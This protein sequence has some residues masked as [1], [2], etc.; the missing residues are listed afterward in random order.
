MRELELHN[1]GY[2]EC[3]V[4]T[5][6][7]GEIFMVDCGSMNRIQR[8]DGG[9]L[10]HQFSESI[11]ER[12]RESPSRAFLL[13]HCHRDHLC[14][15]WNILAR[16]PRYFERI[17]LP[18]SPRDR[19]GR[20]LLLEFA[21]FHTV[22]LRGQSDYARTNLAQLRLFERAARA[23]GPEA[24]RGVG[25]GDSFLFDGVSY[26]VLWPRREDYPFS[27]LFAETVE[28]LNV[29]L[30][31]PFLPDCAAR[32]RALKD[33]FCRLCAQADG[34]AVLTDGIITEC[35]AVLGQI[36]EMAPELGLLPPAPDIREILT[37]PVIETAYSDELN[38]ASVVLQNHRTRE[39]SFDDIL[40]T[41]DAA[42]E[43]FDEIAPQLYEN[44]Y[45]FKAPHHGTASH[46]SHLFSTL[47]A[48]HVLISN[49]D[50]DQ[51]GRIA[52]EY[53]DFP[54]V[55]HCTN[56]GPCAW[57]RGSGCSCSR[58]ALCY[59][60]PRGAGLTI[61]CP[62]VRGETAEAPC[63]IAVIGPRGRRACLCDDLPATP[64]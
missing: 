8:E 15:F 35:A 50:Y 32:F 52:Q 21:L 29:K 44:Y 23:A 4:L 60:V 34:G 18:A 16:E 2:G 12:Y 6:S 47:S 64:R 63:H 49:G 39:A 27:A 10:T 45:I 5:G 58:M 42:P 28:E 43:T 3:I 51:G 14:G 25:A 57:F 36:E 53:V 30:S 33:R 1:V 54:G 13:T 11:R 62:F 37:R 59:E 31:S 22:F 46:W 24:V 20:S 19:R 61:K 26:D 9:E 7:R 38:A 56:C 41:G 40:L 55:K 48:E 17:F